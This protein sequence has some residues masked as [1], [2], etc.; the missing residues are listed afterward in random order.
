MFIAIIQN[1]CLKYFFCIFYLGLFF[2]LHS[3]KATDRTNS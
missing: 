2:L 3:V 1:Y